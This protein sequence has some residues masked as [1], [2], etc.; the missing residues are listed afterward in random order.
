MYI[1][2]T[3]LLSF[4]PAIFIYGHV[5]ADL[6][7]KVDALA[8]AGSAFFFFHLALFAVIFFLVHAVIRKFV[9]IGYRRPGSVI[10]LALMSVFVLALALIALYDVLPGSMIYEMPR[11]VE[12][13]LLKDSFMAAMILI[14]FVYL[15]FD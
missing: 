7:K 11:W 1:L 5:P 13:Y 10:G 3:I 8:P 4:Y 2:L 14:P 9:S 12:E 15:F 6:M